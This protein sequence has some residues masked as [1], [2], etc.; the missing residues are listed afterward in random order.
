M[1][2]DSSRANA[3]ATLHPALSIGYFVFVIG[4]TV[5][6]AHPVLLACS[7][8]GALLLSLQLRGLRAT[9]K[10]LV[11]L[12]GLALFAA[13]INP[14]FNHQG[15]TILGYI[16][17]N[18]L[19]R[20]ALLYGVALAAMLV[21][22]LL[23]FSCY[24]QVVTHE[25]FLAVFGR[26]APALALTTSMALRFAGRYLRQLK[27][28]TAAQR[29]LGRVRQGDG[30]TV[31]QGDGSSVLSEIRQKNRPPV[32]QCTR[33]PV[34]D[35]PPV[36]LRLRSGFAV[37]S[38]LTSW[39]LESALDTADSMHARGYG[40]PG[41]SAYQP[42]RFSARD[43]GAL[44]LMLACAAVVIVAL[45]STVVS[46][47]Y[48]PAFL[49]NQGAGLPGAVRGAITAGAYGAFGLLCLA[50]TLFNLQEEVA[51]RISRSTI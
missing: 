34:S 9:A 32:S 51:W 17:G 49:L 12:A 29:G 20:E 23:W 25:K 8:L 14:L 19:T 13:A 47:Q 40:L 38:I 11:G 30:Y 2:A 27:T 39:A 16:D 37:L 4:V 18:P 33:P 28:I 44:A 15:V 41:R 35:R 7:V 10:L 48:L 1:P 3:F 45:T 43:A 6:T 21:A 36:S 22:V 31:R 24:N 42:F 50:P 26:V 46:A 5:F